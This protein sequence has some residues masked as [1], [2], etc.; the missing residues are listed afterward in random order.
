MA[1]RYLT[2]KPTQF[3]QTKRARV[4]LINRMEAMAKLLR[5]PVVQLFNEMMESELNRMQSL[6]VE[7]LLEERR[8]KEVS[9]DSGNTTPSNNVLSGV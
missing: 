9:S 6:T 7:Q 2:T 8:L 1:V 4:D 3:W 5:I